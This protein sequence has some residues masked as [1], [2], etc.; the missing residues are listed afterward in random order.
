[1]DNVLLLVTQL[2]VNHLVLTM[3]QSPLDVYLVIQLSISYL[4]QIWEL[5]DVEMDLLVLMEYVKFVTLTSA[6]DVL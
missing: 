1:M 5:V 2:I 3:P 4:D 6:Q